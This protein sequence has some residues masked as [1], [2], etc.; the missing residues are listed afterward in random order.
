MGLFL[1]RQTSVLQS[2]IYG[3]TTT[4][5]G[6]DGSDDGKMA[7]APNMPSLSYNNVLQLVSSYRFCYILLPRCHHSQSNTFVMLTIR[8][9]MGYS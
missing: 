5:C 3:K 1:E 6:V 8:K 4:T 2:E 9:P 7:H